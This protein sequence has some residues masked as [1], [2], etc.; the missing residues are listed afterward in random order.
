MI[1]K[2]RVTLAGLG[3]LAGALMLAACHAAGT[4]PQDEAAAASSPARHPR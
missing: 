2:P 4:A 1:C 3:A